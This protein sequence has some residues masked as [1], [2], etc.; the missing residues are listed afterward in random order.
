MIRVPRCKNCLLPVVTCNANPCQTP[1]IVSLE[2]IRELVNPPEIDSHLS[3]LIC[4]IHGEL[5][6]NGCCDDQ[7]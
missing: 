1:P 6:E 2:V 5:L 7:F 4:N 3:D